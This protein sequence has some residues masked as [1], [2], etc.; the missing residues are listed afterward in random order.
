MLL[1]ADGDKV[2]TG[3]PVVEGAKVVATSLGE[4]KDKKVVV[5]KFKSKTRYDRKNGHRQ[6]KTR[7]VIDK[8]V[9]P[10]SKEG[11]SGGA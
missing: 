4:H 8:I 3:M 6:L 5:F 7:L 1:V 9:G 11:D 10:E 2:T